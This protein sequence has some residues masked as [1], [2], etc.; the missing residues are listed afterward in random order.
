M[1]K[2]AAIVEGY[3]DRDAVPHLINLIGNYYGQSIIAHNPIRVGEWPKLRRVGE[4]ERALEL[5]NSRQC[6]A[7]L[8][9]LDLDDDCAALEAQTAYGRIEAWKNNRN[10]NV[11]VV[12]LVREYESLFLSCANVFSDD[13]AAIKSAI[14]G[15]ENVRD[16]KGAIRTL[17]GRRY[18]ETQDQVE[19]TKK[20]DVEKVI[21]NSRSFRKLVKELLGKPYAEIFNNGYMP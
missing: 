7:I 17:I 5:A 12:F 3:G 19:L 8:I 21:V 16:A 9:L 14:E 18:K 20:L 1:K 4:L 13:K 2:I 11:S 15:A 6:D 10:I